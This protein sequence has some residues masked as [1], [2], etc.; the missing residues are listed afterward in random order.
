MVRITQIVK[1]DRE[2]QLSHPIF[3]LELEGIYVKYGPFQKLECICKGYLKEGICGR[4]S[5][6]N[7]IFLFIY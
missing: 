5:S 2:E 1:I 4:L 7:H 6:H 3:A